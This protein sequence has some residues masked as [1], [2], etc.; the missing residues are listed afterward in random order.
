MLR[1]GYT[2]SALG[3]ISKQV[4]SRNNREKQRSLPRPACLPGSSTST[5]QV[6]DVEANQRIIHPETTHANRTVGR[7]SGD[8]VIGRPHRVA[9]VEDFYREDMACLRE[10]DGINLCST[11]S[12]EDVK[13]LER[14][15]RLLSQATLADRHT[16]G[17]QD[18]IQRIP[19]QK[20]PPGSF[21]STYVIQSA[22][23]RETQVTHKRYDVCV[24]GCRAFSGKYEAWEGN[25]QCGLCNRSR[26]RKASNRH[27]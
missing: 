7:A 18:G 12:E 9:A 6:L 5:S 11:I 25:E 14:R 23:E 10:K 27:P 20:L 16:R 8:I 26:Q 1:R 21:D 13:T 19:F 17:T 2:P 22:L 4:A 15:K 3:D 24:A